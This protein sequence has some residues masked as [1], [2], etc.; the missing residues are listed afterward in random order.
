MSP[1]RRRYMLRLAGRI[2]VLLA[3]AIILLLKPDEY[4]ILNGWNFFDKFSVL[5]LL[6]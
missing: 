3:C 5:H 4:E 1:M 6:K 2:A